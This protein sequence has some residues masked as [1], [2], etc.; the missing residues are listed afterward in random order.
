MVVRANIAHTLRGTSFAVSP[1]RMDSRYE[2]TTGAETK[3][4]LGKTD[5]AI[6]CQT[7]FTNLVPLVSLPLLGREEVFSGLPLLAIGAIISIAAM[8][9]QGG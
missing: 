7:F 5:A 6:L 4:A 1:M 2:N 8:W 9:E 3:F